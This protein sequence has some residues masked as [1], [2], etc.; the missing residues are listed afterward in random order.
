MMPPEVIVALCSL[1][2]TLAGSIGGIF[3][4][5]KLT[6]YRIEQL[7]KKM[8]KHNGLMERMTIVEQNQKAVWK[9]I[10]ESKGRILALEE[11]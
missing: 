1:V 4:S 9:Q 8:D 7:E 3:I 6:N 11:R 2:G 10:D 5:G